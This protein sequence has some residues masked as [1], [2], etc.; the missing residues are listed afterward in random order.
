MREQHSLKRHG[1]LFSACFGIFS[2][3]L[4]WQC[5]HLLNI[6]QG[7]PLNEVLTRGEQVVFLA[8]LAAC[9]VLGFLLARLVSS[10]VKSLLDALRR[11]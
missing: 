5:V 8:L 9:A 7:V 2:V 6:P 1:Y 11:K 4:M 3:L 10:A